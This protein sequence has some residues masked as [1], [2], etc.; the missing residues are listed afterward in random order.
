MSRIHE[1]A[2]GIQQ[3]S[4]VDD[5]NSGKLRPVQELTWLVRKAVQEDKALQGLSPDHKISDAKLYFQRLREIGFIFAEVFAFQE[6][7]WQP[8]S[9]DPRIIDLGGDIGGFSVLYWKSVAPQAKITLV[10]ANPSTARV[11]SENFQRKGLQDVE[12][13]NAAVSESG[14]EIDLHF[15]GYNPSNFVGTRSNLDSSRYHIVK[16]PGIKLSEIIG[17]E[18][19]DL[20]KMDIEGAEGGVFRELEK[21]GKLGLVNDIMME[22]HN[23]PA[24]PTNS[25]TEVVQILQDA[26]FC[27]KNAHISGRI[28]SKKNHPVEIYSIRPS[29]EMLFAFTAKRT[30]ESLTENII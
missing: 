13:I 19:V 23:D 6:Y 5:P 29:D 3:F 20:L 18:P 21:S 8:Q 24:N 7:S 26:G 4:R 10:E 14:G 12:V 22:F 30:P 2:R 1:I 27:I 11:V 28:R 25:I 17:D 15:S 9:N 16:V